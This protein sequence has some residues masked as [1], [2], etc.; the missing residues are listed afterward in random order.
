MVIKGCET[1][2]N[3]FAT[4]DPAVTQCCICRGLGT[5]PEQLAHSDAKEKDDTD[6]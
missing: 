1:C 5:E 4:E 2:P 3:Q 6:E